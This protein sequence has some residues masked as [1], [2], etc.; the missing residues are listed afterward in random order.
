MLWYRAHHNCP[1]CKRQLKLSE[2]HDITL[3]P[4]ELRLHVGEEPVVPG[5]RK[6]IVAKKM[7]IYTEFGAEKLA[8]IN[9]ID[10]DG[11]SFTTKVDSL[12][13]HLLWLRDSD[14]GAKSVI[15][16]Q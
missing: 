9:R 12:V 15:F 13:R 11:P 8:E 3:K 4:R 5:L 16:S 1:M 7:S 2:L 6:S 14:P 10:L